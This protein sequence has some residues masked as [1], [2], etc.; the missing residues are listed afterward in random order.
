MCTQRSTLR[1]GSFEGSPSIFLADCGSKLARY[2]PERPAV[3]AESVCGVLDRKRPAG[4]SVETT[5]AVAVS[6]ANPNGCDEQ[7]GN[8]FEQVAGTTFGRRHDDG[9]CPL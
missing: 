9:E 6:Q 1:S 7:D 5:D 8:E 4:G 2:E 3:H